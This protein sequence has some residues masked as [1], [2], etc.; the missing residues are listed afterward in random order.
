MTDE[1]I[2]ALEYL[3]QEE[4]EEAVEDIQLTNWKAFKGSNE[5]LLHTREDI[6]VYFMKLLG[7]H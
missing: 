5:Y 4:I 6:A 7:R 1:V 3:T 2:E